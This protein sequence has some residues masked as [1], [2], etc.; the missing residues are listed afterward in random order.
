MRNASKTA[1]VCAAVLIGSL[2]PVLSAGEGTVAKIRVQP[3]RA[4]DCSSLQ[5]LVDYATRGCKTNDEKAVKLYYIVRQMFYHHA[6]PR[7]RK[8]ISALKAINVY[9]FALCGGQHTVLATLGKTAGGGTV[10]NLAADR[11][12]MRVSLPFTARQV[13]DER[14]D[15]NLPD[16]KVFDFTL[17]PAQAVFFGLA[18]P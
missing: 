13:R 9:G 17:D 12:A 15:R 16:G 3:D 7:E 10:Q 6:Y 11:I 8:P 18:K 1:I 14:A 4:P 2:F 5:A